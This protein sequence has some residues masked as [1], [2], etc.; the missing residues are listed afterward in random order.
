MERY[1]IKHH[2]ILSISVMEVKLPVFFCE[3]AALTLEM[4]SNLLACPSVFPPIC[5][6]LHICRNVFYL[7]VNMAVSEDLTGPHYTPLG[8]DVGDL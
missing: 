5:Q 3:K 6:S 2:V 1:N 4:I 8:P 7:P